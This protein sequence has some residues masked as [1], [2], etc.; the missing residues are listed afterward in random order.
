MSTLPAEGSTTPGSTPPQTGAA[1]ENTGPVIEA[2][3]PDAENKGPE[4]GGQENGTTTT[5]VVA[6]VKKAIKPTPKADKEVKA[7]STEKKT[8]P[9]AEP[10]PP[11]VKAEKPK[12]EPKPPREKKPAGP[13]KPAKEAM[14]LRGRYSFGGAFLRVCLDGIH[15][16]IDKMIAFAAASNLLTKKNPEKVTHADQVQDF[17]DFKDKITTATAAI[18]TA[19]EGITDEAK[20]AEAVEKAT[21]ARDKIIQSLRDTIIGH[22]VLTLK[23]DTD[24]AR[25]AE[26]AAMKDAED[27]LFPRNFRLSVEEEAAE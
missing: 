23:G 18:D 14:G 22:I 26:L 11:K 16:D 15:H 12:K 21:E 3:K 17:M 25:K 19:A 7:A 13:R 5:P 27:K 24:E 10:K 1:S 8:K 2:G 20:A 4:T 6:S 9:K